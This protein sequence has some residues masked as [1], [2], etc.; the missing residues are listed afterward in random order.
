MSGTREAEL[1]KL[2]ENTFRHVNIALVNELAMFAADL[3]ID[4][5][6]AD[7]RRRRPNPSAS[8]ASPRARA[9]AATACRSIRATCRGS[10]ERTLGQPFRFVELA[11]DVNEHMPDYVV[12]RLMLA[13]NRRGEPVNGSRVLLLGLAYKRNT[14]DAR[15][16]PATVIAE[17]LLALGAD[18]RAADPHV[19]RRQVDERVALVE[20]SDDEVAAA[21]LVLLITDHDSF[22]LDRIVARASF[23]LDTRHRGPADHVEYL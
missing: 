2:L 10:V 9:S 11:N 15:E 5:W 14:G 22:D 17:L 3:D 7:R 6:E 21:D 4:V 18:V 23:V 1:T 12:R 19:D 16:S 20:A 8:C 13:L